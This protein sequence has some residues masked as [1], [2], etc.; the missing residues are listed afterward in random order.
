[1]SKNLFKAFWNSTISLAK[2]LILWGRLLKIL[3]A[4]YYIPFW[5]FVRFAVG[6]C[7]L[8]LNLVIVYITWSPKLF[9]TDPSLRRLQFSEEVKHSNTVLSYTST[10]ILYVIHYINCNLFWYYEVRF[11]ISKFCLYTLWFGKYKFLYIHILLYIH[12]F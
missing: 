2:S 12:I 7:K 4:E 9:V 1:M 3:I 5:N 10:N 8:V 6:G 11:N